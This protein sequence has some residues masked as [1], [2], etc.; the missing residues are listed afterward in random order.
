MNSH[1]QLLALYLLMVS[2]STLS[3]LLKGSTSGTILQTNFSNYAGAHYQLVLSTVPDISGLVQN[4]VVSLKPSD[5]MGVLGLTAYS[6]GSGP[7]PVTHEEVA[8][9]G[10]LHRQFPYTEG[11]AQVFLK[12]LG[13]KPKSPDQR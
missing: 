5:V 1:G 9:I 7:C 4:G 2:D 10:A 11:D 12:L 3:R 13:K 8:I 6:G